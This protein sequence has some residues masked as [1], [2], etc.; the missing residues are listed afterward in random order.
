M[1]THLVAAVCKL[2]L[3]DAGAS[4]QDERD[5]VLSPIVVLWSGV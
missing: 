2:T 4:L 3:G 5:N 1:A